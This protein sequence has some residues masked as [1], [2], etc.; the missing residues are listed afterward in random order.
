M[1]CLF[2]FL[3]TVGT[4][5]I[6]SKY[7]NY[8]VS[9]LSRREAIAS[10]AAVT[11]KERTDR[12]IDVGIS[13]A[14]RVQF[15]KLIEAGKWDE[16]IKVMER[17]PKD[18]PYIE[19]VALFDPQGIFEAVTPLTPELS[20]IIGQDFS[21]RD[22]YQGVSKNW[23]PYVA[24]AIKPA[25]PLGYNL[26]PVA[27]PITSGSG[28]RLGILLLNIK[29]D[30]ITAWSKSINVGPA[31]FVYIVDRKGH[32]LMHPTLLPAE[33]IV[34]FSSVPSV[35]KVLKGERG[36][37]ITWNPI[38][39]EERVTAYEPISEHGWGVIVAQPTKSAFMERDR[40]VR[41]DVILW[42]LIII[43]LETVTFLLLRNKNTMKMQLEKE[44]ALT[45]M[46]ESANK[47]LKTLNESVSAEAE[48]KLKEKVLQLETLNQNMMGRELKMIELKK[49]AQDLRTQLGEHA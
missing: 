23:E 25:V 40:V 49:E 35:Q 38:E 21:Y 39:N 3:S 12:V 46:V 43:T 15:Q 20:T 41:S 2:L 17:V 31:A 4:Y 33:D 7:S 19:R 48:R 8:T 27:V 29:L 14:T 1:F 45:A 36:I 47:E 32:L 10:L 44:K 16:A 9:A 24:E 30:T 22:Y 5:L 13:L 34:D 28:E 6:Y 11:L 18:F 37:E 42:I 26:V